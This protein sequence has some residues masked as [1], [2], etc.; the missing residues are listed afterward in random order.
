M[1]VAQIPL[2]RNQS[3]MPLQQGIR[4]HYGLEFEQSVAPYCLGLARLKR[5]LSIGEPDSLASQPF[6]AQAIRGLEKLD[7]EQLMPMDPVLHNH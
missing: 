3:P 2:L 4:R 6:F 7:G 1:P 5:I